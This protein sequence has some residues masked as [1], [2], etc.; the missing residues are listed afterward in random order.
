[1]IQNVDS[2]YFQSSLQT[3]EITITTESILFP[4]LTSL[5]IRGYTDHLFP[6]FTQCPQLQTLILLFESLTTSPNPIL[7]EARHLLLQNIVELKLFI[8]G[9]A[10]CL[11]HNNIIISNIL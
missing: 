4:N 1:L 5:I 7:F 8:S 11:S 9:D 6:W 3:T 2:L 10:N